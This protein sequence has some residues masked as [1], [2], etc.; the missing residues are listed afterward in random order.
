MYL[1]LAQAAMKAKWTRPKTVQAASKRSRYWKR[2]AAGVCV[3]CEQPVTRYRLCDDC[4]S[5]KKEKYK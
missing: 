3:T 4:R 5:D 2:V 1:K